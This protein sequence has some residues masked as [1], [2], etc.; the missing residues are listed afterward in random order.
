MKKL[1]ST[2]ALPFLLGISTFAAEITVDT[3]PQTLI[4]YADQAIASGTVSVDTLLTV[5][6]TIHEN[7]KAEITS[8]LKE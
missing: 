6:Q 5:M 7:Q 8:A 4:T 3:I 2:L 1:L